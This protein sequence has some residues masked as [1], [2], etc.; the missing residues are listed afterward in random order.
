MLGFFLTDQMSTSIWRHPAQI[1]NCHLSIHIH[2]LINVIPKLP[3]LAAGTNMRLTCLVTCGI[4]TIHNILVHG[5]GM[6]WSGMEFYIMHVLS[7]PCMHSTVQAGGE[8]RISL[9]YDLIPFSHISWSFCFIYGGYILDFFKAIWIYL[10]R[11]VQRLCSSK[12][13]AWVLLHCCDCSTAYWVVVWFLA[14]L[15]I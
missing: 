9:G 5:Y 11:S 7:R 12:E 3:V 8:E 14:C 13:E 10:D 4:P 1:A 15:H 6:E 2:R